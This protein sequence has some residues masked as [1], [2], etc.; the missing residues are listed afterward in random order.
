MTLSVKN[1]Y[2]YSYENSTYHSS[3]IELKLKRKSDDLLIGAYYVPTAVFA[4]LSKISF[5][6]PPEKVQ[7]W[8]TT[9]YKKMK[10]PVW[11]GFQTF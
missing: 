11:K 2:E 8:Y 10:K 1:T 9:V 5:F 7:N 4:M 6:I 3:G